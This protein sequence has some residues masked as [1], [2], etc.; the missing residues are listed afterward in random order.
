MKIDIYQK[1]I[2]TLLADLSIFEA[3]F[4][5]LQLMLQFRS[6]LVKIDIYQMALEVSALLIN[7]EI[8]R[9]DIT[10]NS[11]RTQDQLLVCMS[12]QMVIVISFKEIID[13]Q[14]KIIFT[15]M[16]CIRRTICPREYL[17][18]ICQN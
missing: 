17:L 16:L 12:F 10:H 9:S 5:F 7:I 15:I 18:S 11:D 2:D 1:V 13:P 8:V 4:S 6:L 14:N 3:S